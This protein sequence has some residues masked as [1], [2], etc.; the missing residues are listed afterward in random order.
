MKTITIPLTYWQKCWLNLT[1]E[2]GASTISQFKPF[3]QALKNRYS[4]VDWRAELGSTDVSI[5]YTDEKL[6]TFFLLKWS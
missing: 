5:S 2:F 4:I 6:I 1:L 3:R